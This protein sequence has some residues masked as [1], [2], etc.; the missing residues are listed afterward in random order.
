MVRRLLSLAVVFVLSVSA[1]GLPSH[2]ATPMRLYIPR[3]GLNA[4]VTECALVNGWHDTTHLGSGVCHLEGTATIAH[5]WA[6]VVLA[7]HTPGG[8]SNLVYV[9]AGDQIMIWDD[10]AVEVY[11]ITLITM[12]AIDDTRWLMPTENETLTL[13]TCNGD[14]RLIVHAERVN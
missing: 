7:G 12:A 3:I 14:A 5:E 2:A 13:I 8:F 10:Y 1:A 4:E 6:R 9:E 11:K